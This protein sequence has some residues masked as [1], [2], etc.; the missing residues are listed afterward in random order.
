MIKS[1]LIKFK[2]NYETI[3]KMDWWQ[4]FRAANN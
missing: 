1:A 3:I 2:I 4:K